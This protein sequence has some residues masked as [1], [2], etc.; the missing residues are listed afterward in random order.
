VYDQANVCVVCRVGS[1]HSVAGT[2]DVTRVCEPKEDI[3]RCFFFI[4]FL[5]VALRDL[6]TTSQ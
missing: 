1:D 3:S 2:L 6:V 4:L 5:N